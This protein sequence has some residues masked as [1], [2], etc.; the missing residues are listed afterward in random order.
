MDEAAILKVGRKPL[1]DE[2]QKIVKSFSAPG[3]PADKTT[4]SKTLGYFHRLGLSIPSFFFPYIGNEKNDP[5]VKVLSIYTNGVNMVMGQVAEFYQDPELVK[6]YQDTAAIMLQIILGDEDVANRTQSLAPKD[7]KKEWTDAAKDVVDFELQL[8]DI[9]SSPQDASDPVNYMTPRTIEQLSTLTP[10]VDWA[11]M[12]QETIPSGV[13]YTRPIIVFWV[14]QLT[15]IDALLQKTPS[16]TLQHYFSWLLIQNHADKLAGPYKQPLLD[17]NNVVWGDSLD[18]KVGSW[19]TCI[20]LVNTNLNHL[21]G[22]YF[23]RETFKGNSRKEV[24]AT[25]DNIIA[26][27][28][29]NFNTTA[30]LDKTT[31]DGAIK[32]LRSIAFAIGYSTHD[33]DG[34]SSKSLDTFYKTYPVTANDYFGN[35][36]NYFAWSATL[37]YSQ[38]LQPVNREDMYEHVSSEAAS[39][40]FWFNMINIPAGILQD[41]VFNLENPEYLNYGSAGVIAAH[42]MGV[43]SFEFF[44]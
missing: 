28:E 27:Y 13:N 15:K 43:S 26:T 14:P 12:L 25:I 37:S 8:A 24:M 17:W 7:V 16:S 11:L 42:E 33:P 22:H 10:S 1:A 31:R 21:V 18:I 6:Q 23:I 4:L 20:S 39:N 3:S 44:F 38:L 29:K 19:E 35:Q 36:F 41:P 5:L 32:K 2:I 30:W 40:S 34:A 9:L